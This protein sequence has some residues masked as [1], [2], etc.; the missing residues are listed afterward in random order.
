MQEFCTPTSQPRAWGMV[1]LESSREPPRE[2]LESKC[3]WTTPSSA[4]NERCERATA[5]ASTC[6][7]SP[8]PAVAS[9]RA[10]PHERHY[11]SSALLLHPGLHSHE[12]SHGRTPQR[13]Q[14]ED[15]DLVGSRRCS[16]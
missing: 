9:V 16:S 15:N 14:R 4:H 5:T 1:G 10:A 6:V 13:W 12:S 7:W 8:A 2:R 11:H 3:R